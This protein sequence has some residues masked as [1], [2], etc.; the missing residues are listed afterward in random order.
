MKKIVLT[1]AL[2]LIAATA[3]DAQKFALVD[4]DYILKAIPAYETANEQLDQLSKKWQKEVE[5]MLAEV[6]TMYKNYQTELVFL[7]DDMKVKRE[8]EIVAKEKE[9]NE[10]KRKYF[11]VEGELY[12]KRESLMKP[13]HEEIFTAVQSVATEKGY[14]LIIDKSSDMSLVYAAPK[15][16]VSDE[17]LEKLGYSK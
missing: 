15:I 10:L 3:V 12:K 13:I 16:D 6:Q 11:G 8:E 5:N 1:L 4:M 9:A 14:Q 7:T 2:A 17:V